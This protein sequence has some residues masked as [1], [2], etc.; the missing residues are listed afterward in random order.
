[1]PYK[2][3]NKK[4]NDTMVSTSI[5]SYEAQQIQKQQHEAE[6]EKQKY[7]QK[8]VKYIKRGVTGKH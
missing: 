6:A 4:A 1:M 5:L 3:K 2:S 7:N 8:P